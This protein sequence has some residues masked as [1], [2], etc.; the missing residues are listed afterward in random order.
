MGIV[1]R[2]DYLVELAH[3]VGDDAALQQAALYC[4]KSNA[5]QSQNLLSFLFD[6]KEFSLLEHFTFT[7]KVEAPVAVF[8]EL[9]RER[10]IS[11][12]KTTGKDR[13]FTGEFY[14]PLSLPPIAGLRITAAYEDAFTTYQQLLAE[15]SSPEEARLV[16]PTATYADMMVTLSLRELFKLESKTGTDD[17]AISNIFNQMLLIVEQSFPLTIS[18]YYKTD[19]VGL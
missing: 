3:S 17:G 4:I 12:F 6:S 18:E 10:V 7:F 1:T 16:L 8:R 14:L 9:M 2:T 11:Y 13:V 19:K 15:G 5:N